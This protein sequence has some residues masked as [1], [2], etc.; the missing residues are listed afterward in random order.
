MFPIQTCHEHRRVMPV[1]AGALGHRDHPERENRLRHQFRRRARVTPIRIATNT[2]EKADQ[3]REGHPIAIAI[4][5]DGKT[6]Y[7]AN[8]GS[9]TVTPISTATNKAGKAITIGKD[10]AY[11]AITPDGKTAYVANSGSDTVTPISTATNKAGK[12]IRSGRIPATSRSPRT[13]RPLTSP[14]AVGDT[15]T[16][17]STATNTVGK[18]ITVG[19]NPRVHRDHPERQD[20]LRRQRRQLGIGAP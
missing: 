19:K 3:R 13:A 2:P 20:R 4:T 9:D 14:T 6:A 10:P 15:V 11:I 16:L 1:T 17:I 8:S 5:P 18:A 7:V 12:P